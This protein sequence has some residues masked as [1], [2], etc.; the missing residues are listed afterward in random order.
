HRKLETR[1]PQCWCNEHV[2]VGGTRR[3]A[4]SC[5]PEAPEAVRRAEPGSRRKCAQLRRDPEYAPVEERAAWSI[6]VGDGEREHGRSARRSGPAERRRNVAALAG[7][8]RRDHT[9]GM[10]GGAR[11][12]ERGG[13]CSGRDH[14]SIACCGP[15]ASP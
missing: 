2:V 4:W 10:E 15:G 7:V 8:D 3:R 5:V 6:G 13:E 9:T 11:Q 14:G 12:N 1:R